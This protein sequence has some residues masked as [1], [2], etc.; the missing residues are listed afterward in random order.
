MNSTEKVSI[1]SEGLKFL[2]TSKEA[3]NSLK[4]TTSFSL[5]V[6]DHGVWVGGRVVAEPS[7]QL[8]KPQQ[9]TFSTDPV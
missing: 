4:C 3:G 2:L 9:G 6:I 8:R 1:A 7:G 5:A